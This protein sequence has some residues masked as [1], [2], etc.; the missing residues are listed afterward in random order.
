[1]RGPMTSPDSN[2]PTWV[3][4]G[5]CQVGRTPVEAYVGIKE[6]YLGSFG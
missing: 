2:H 6:A 5:V 4:L 3:I 1:M